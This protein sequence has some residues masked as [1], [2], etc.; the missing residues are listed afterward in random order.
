[1]EQI[2]RILCAACWYEELELAKPEALENRGILPYNVDKGIVFSGWRHAN[3]IYQ[4]VAIT[5]LPQHK[6]GK[7]IQGFLTSHNRFVDREEGANIALAAKQVTKLK[8]S[9]K[10]LYSEDLY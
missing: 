6:A 8:Y 10:L 7:E 2:E 9:S 3:C 1:M 5:G 4:M